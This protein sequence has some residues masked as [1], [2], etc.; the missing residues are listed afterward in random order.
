MSQRKAVPRFRSLLSPDLQLLDDADLLSI[1]AYP[2]SLAAPWIRANMVSSIDG[3]AAVRG[4]SKGLTSAADRRLFHLLRSAAD[5]I[6]IGAGTAR[7]EPYANHTHQVVVI[8]RSGDLPSNFFTGIRPIV[9]TTESL[10][11]ERRIQLSKVSEVI[12]CGRHDVDFNLVLELFVERGW[13]KVLCEGGPALLG[14][15]NTQGLIDEV[16]L[17]IAPVLVGSGTSLLQEGL[18]ST[19]DFQLSSLLQAEGNLFARYVTH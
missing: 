13:L 10:T 5:V 15:L 7:S 4:V 16:A 19:R 8:S 6:L 9:L 12:N 14:A 3:S 1:Y 18:E 11:D 2:T 17:T